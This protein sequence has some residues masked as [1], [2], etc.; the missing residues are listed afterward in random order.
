MYH[1]IFNFSNKIKLIII[2]LLS[3]VF[4]ESVEIVRDTYG[5]PH[6]IG[7]TPGDCA[8]GLGIAMY[9]DHP[10]ALIDN[11]LTTRGELTCH[12]GSQ[13]FNQDAFIRSLRLAEK[14]S[15]AMSTISSD[16]Y[17]FLTGLANGINYSIENFPEN[18]P[19]SIDVNVLLPITPSD[20]YTSSYLKSIT[21][22]WNQ[23]VKDAGNYYVGQSIFSNIQEDLSNQWVVTP[24]RTVDD[25]LYLLCDP[26]LPFNGLTASW[27]AHLKSLDG[28]LNFSG[29]YFIGGPH[30][31]MGHNEHFAWSHTANKP[32][33]A[34]A[35]IVSLDPN[36]EEHYLLDGVSKP[37]TIWTETI[38]FPNG[39]EQTVL[40]RQ[41]SDHGVFVM[42]INE[43]TALFA[44]IEAEN[45]VSG[46]EQGYRMMT[47][48]SV[49]EWDDALSLHQ[50][51][52]WNSLGGDE[53]GNIL[54]YYSG[55]V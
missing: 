16:I 37:F 38:I 6:I 22:E 34:D 12:Y 28:A 50:Y 49:S 5:I 55:K 44:K 13:F 51:D 2:V 39:T 47:A 4:C 3:I 24:G 35:F 43:T 11:I 36:T 15:I 27:S 52:K 19:T 8:F 48:E 30:P 17:L 41:S 45:I 1:S 7:A 25:A 40:M 9:Q 10:K 26:H 20:I 53:Q 32:D 46:F 18:I 14:T 21:H 42:N 23:F 54:Y 29:F 31:V 33:F